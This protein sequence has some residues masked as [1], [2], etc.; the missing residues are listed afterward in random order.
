MQ[1]KIVMIIAQN[2]FR[3]EE[4]NE[5]KK[6]LEDRGVDIKMASSSSNPA[7]GMFGEVITPDLTLNQINVPE[8]DAIVFIGGSGAR[9]YWED[10]QAL[11]LARSAVDEGKILGAI[12]IAPVILANAGLLRG[13]RVTVFSSEVNTIEAKGAIFTG[14]SVEKDDNI[15]T[16][17]GPEA[18]K[19]FGELLAT[20]IG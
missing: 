3:D 19:E 12:C 20:T 9:E 15:I 6:V 18:A 4:L 8:Y 2:N 1:K 11:S 5:S 7:K 13:R 10:A 17:C 14:K 16:A